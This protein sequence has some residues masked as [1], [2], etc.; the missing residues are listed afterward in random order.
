MADEVG[1]PLI[2]LT[3][4]EAVVRDRPNVFRLRTT[5][6]D[7]LRYLVNYAFEE[8]GARRFAV[9]YPEDGYGRGM[10]DQFWEMVEERGGW[11][12][13]ASGYEPDAT[14]FGESIRRM[15]GYVLLTRSEQGA[16]IER[17]AFIRRGRRLPIEHRPLVRR[18]ADTMLGPESEPLPPIVDFDALFIPDGYGK[19]GLLAP[20]LAFHDLTGVQLLGP[21]GW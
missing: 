5:P 7:E 17:E 15:I 11:L 4:Q 20:Q 9:L 16:L 10:R 19:I 6:E 3:T 18:I 13:A 21:G 14:D 8:L 12:V 2:A 1:I